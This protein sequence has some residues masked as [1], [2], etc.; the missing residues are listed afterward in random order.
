MPTVA[1]DKEEL[2]ERLGHKYGACTRGGSCTRSLRLL[3]AAPEEFDRLLF[4]FGLEL[5]EDVRTRLHA[6]LNNILNTFI[7]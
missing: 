1:V 6:V 5:D 2:W 4:E 7:T 3:F